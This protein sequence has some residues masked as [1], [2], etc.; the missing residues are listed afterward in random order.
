MR[1]AK[2]Y[3]MEAY[4]CPRVSQEIVLAAQMQL[5]SFRR[6]MKI[7]PVESEGEDDGEDDKRESCCE[8][9]TSSIDDLIANVIE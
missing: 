3:E 2:R 1:A 8:R 9:L 4:V 6:I 5:K 7:E